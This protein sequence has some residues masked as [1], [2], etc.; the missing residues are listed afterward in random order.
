[1]PPL[2]FTPASISYLTQFILSLVIFIYLALHMRRKE[3]RDAQAGLV[4][5]MFGGLIVFLGL[6]FL[7]VSLL[8]TE[9]LYVVFVENTV[10]AIVLALLLQFAYHFPQRYARRKW[11][12]WTALG[13]S[14]LYVAYEGQY[15]WYRYRLLLSEATVDYRPQTADYIFMALCTWVLL[16]FVRQSLAADDRRVSWLR[17]LVAPEG[18]GAQAGRDFALIFSSFLILS[19][20][21]ILRGHSL[22]STSIYNISL[23]VGTLL[24]LWLF[25]TSYIN[26]VR[27]RFSFTFKMTVTT[28][29]L[30]FMFFGA[31]GWV[32]APFYARLYLPDVQAQ[33]TL[34]FTPNVAGGYDISA[35]PY[36]FESEYGDRLMVSSHGSGRNQRVEFNFPFFGQTYSEIYITSVGLIKM[37]L[38]LYHPNLQLRQAD[39]PAIFPLL[40]D[41]EPAQGGGVFTHVEAGKLTVTWDHLPALFQPGHTFTFQAVLYA[42]GVFDFS[43]AEIPERFIFALDATPSANFWRRGVSAGAL[44]ATSTVSDLSQAGQT[45]PSGIIQN[46]HQEF[47]QHL[48]ELLSPIFWLVFG[49]CGLLLIALPIVFHYTFNRPLDALIAGVHAIEAGRLDTQVAVSYQDEIG[50][51]TQAFNRLVAR[52]SQMVNDLEMQVNQRTQELVRTNTELC[53]EIKLREASQRE[54]IEQQRQLAAFEEREQISRDLHDGLGQFIGY[55]SVQTQATRDMLSNGYYQ[56][57]E[58]SLVRI[59]QAAEKAQVDIRRHILGLRAAPEQKASLISSLHECIHEYKAKTN[60]LVHLSLP[61]AVSLPSFPPAVEMQILHIIQ[62]ALVNVRKHA[63]AQQVN[64]VFTFDDRSLQIMI[65]DDGVGFY[66][67]Q[68]MRD[69]SHHFGLAMMSERAQSIGGRLEIRT[70]PGEG[71]RVILYVPILASMTS[72]GSVQNRTGPRIL[73]ADDSAIFTEGL[74]NLLTARGFVVVGSARDGLEAQ[75]KNRLLRPDII[76][77]DMMMPHCDG[78]ETIKAI[79][80]E[81]PDVK[82]LVLTASEKEGHLVAAIQNGALGY[83]LKG[84]DAN[85]FCAQLNELAL[86]ETILPSAL[87]MQVIQHMELTIPP[88]EDT[89]LG[90]LTGRQ[91]LILNL[92]AQGLTYKQIGA[93]LHLSERTIKYH[94]GQILESLRLQSRSQAIAYAQQQR[95]QQD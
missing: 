47:R 78:V 81:F 36:S 33:Q 19:I 27:E 62:E 55:I 7:D 63:Q 49:S 86:G 44:G 16:A 66:I 75:E 89:N 65:V 94:M 39:M 87:A 53:D 31:I 9:R 25:S 84:M 58:D 50:F 52:L 22:L 37:G 42:D 15:A 30:L 18:K 8:S 93:Q 88:Q 24:T 76:V 43:Y 1:M 23:S 51:L 48:H 77:M 68:R 67:Q 41:L 54:T 28:I 4:L 90:M 80:A 26:H 38:P 17:K 91:Q 34:R 71:T 45:G 64:V 61:E 40:I 32:V 92:V 82:I 3:N 35:V 60:I 20:I 79:K 11:E 70:Q 59:G 56:A 46:F 6:L 83:L 12:G 95:G 57:V 14:L 72:N 5:A 69:S 2:F 73:I 74:T 13:F 21:N 85:E 10:L 29:L